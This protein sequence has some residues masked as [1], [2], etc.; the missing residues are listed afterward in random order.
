MKENTGHGAIIAGPPYFKDSEGVV[1]TICRECGWTE[2]YSDVL[3]AGPVN[4][5]YWAVVGLCFG[6]VLPHVKCSPE[7]IA[8]KRPWEAYPREAAK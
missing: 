3:A 4:G 8:A 6:S 2:I 1:A 5:H 7:D